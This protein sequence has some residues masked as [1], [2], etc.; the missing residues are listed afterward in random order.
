MSISSIMRIA[1]LFFLIGTLPVMGQDR[2]EKESH[3][4]KCFSGK[5]EITKTHTQSGQDGEL[6]VSLP[7]NAGSAS[8]MWV[9]FGE[10]KKG[11]DI[12]NLKAG[13]Y[14]LLIIDNKNCQTVIDN[15]Q[16]KESQ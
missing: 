12:K 3:R 9:V 4:S 15:I 7:R 5:I 2:V 1:I 10:T 14:N 6:S 8:L 16:I 13:Y 11:K